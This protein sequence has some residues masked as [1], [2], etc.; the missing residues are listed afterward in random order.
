[1]KANANPRDT[2]EHWGSQ[3]EPLDTE[4]RGSDTELSEE[5]VD[6]KEYPSGN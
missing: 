6:V 4:Q 5:Y 1:M 3:V 2:E